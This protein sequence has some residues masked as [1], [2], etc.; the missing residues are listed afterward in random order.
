MKMRTCIETSKVGT[1]ANHLLDLIN[2]IEEEVQVGTGDLITA[3]T[4]REGIQKGKAEARVVKE[5][6]VKALKVSI[7]TRNTNIRK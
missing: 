4:R 2:T 7:N 5:R 1:E 3:K 6:M